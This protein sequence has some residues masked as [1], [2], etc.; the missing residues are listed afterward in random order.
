MPLTRSSSCRQGTDCLPNLRK[1]YRRN[2][3]AF[4]NF[5]LIITPPSGIDARI[6]K[7][8]ALRFVERVE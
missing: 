5:G 8:V 7:C 2:L 3:P 6:L 4:S 1:P